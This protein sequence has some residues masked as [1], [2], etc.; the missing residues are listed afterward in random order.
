VKLYIG[1]RAGSGAVKKIDGSGAAGKWHG[2][3]TLGNMM[4]INVCK[5]II[6]KKINWKY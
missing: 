2:S 5:Y 6:A 1:A 4:L 3:A